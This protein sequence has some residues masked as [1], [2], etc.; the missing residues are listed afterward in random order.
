MASIQKHGGENRLTYTSQ[1]GT[2]IGLSYK[3]PV[4]VLTSD[5]GAFISDK[6]WSVTS[7]KHRNLFVK[8]HGVKPQQVTEDMLREMAAPAKGVW[9]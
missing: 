7:S 6:F 8:E 9:R 1:D 2:I 4:I 5:G 3:V